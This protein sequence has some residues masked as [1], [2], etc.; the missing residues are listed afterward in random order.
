MEKQ[1]LKEQ[2]R[3][4]YNYFIQCHET[5]PRFVEFDIQTP[6]NTKPV[7]CFMH[8]ESNSADWLYKI[9]EIC[10]VINIKFNE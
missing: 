9:A 4:K 1:E 6:H 2:L 8:I 10:E 5:L 7:H 3:R